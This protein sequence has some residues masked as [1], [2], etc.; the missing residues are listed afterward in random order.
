MSS[1]REF[2]QPDQ[3][4]E[5]FAH[6]HFVGC[7]NCRYAIDVTVPAFRHCDVILGLLYEMIDDT[8][9]EEVKSAIA[10]MRGEYDQRMKWHLL[11]DGDFFELKQLWESIQERREQG[12]A[13]NKKRRRKR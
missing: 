10:L 13:G 6:L 5:H 7:P 3:V 2:E 9:I 1:H 11:D 8:N 12:R 4:G